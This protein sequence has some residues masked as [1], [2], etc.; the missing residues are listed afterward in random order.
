[1]IR[2]EPGGPI[3]IVDDDP[4]DRLILERVLQ[5]A[6][7]SNDV[8]VLESAPRLLAHLDAVE[9]G[10]A[11]AP[12]LVLLDVNMPEMDGFAAFEAIRGRPRFASAPAVILL[13]SSEAERDRA[14]A[15]A[16][17]ADVFMSKVSGIRAYVERVLEHLEPTDPSPGR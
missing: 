10:E 16:V 7:F 2:V 11:P 12:S 3:L 14:R 6:G 15:L 5:R 9:A 4:A 13:S 8:V 1:M 17:G